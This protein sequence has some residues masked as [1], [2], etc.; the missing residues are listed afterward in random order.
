MVSHVDCRRRRAAFAFSTTA[1]TTAATA[2]ALVLQLRTRVVAL[3][4]RLC[5]LLLCRVRIWLLLILMVVC[6]WRQRFVRP[7][8]R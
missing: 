1:T 8:R 2:A 5:D 6:W 4:Q 3:E 7:W